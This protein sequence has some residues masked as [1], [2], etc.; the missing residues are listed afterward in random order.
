VLFHQNCVVDTKK[1]AVD[2]RQIV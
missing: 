1:F 2:I